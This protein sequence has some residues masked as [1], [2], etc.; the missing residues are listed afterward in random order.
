[1][2]LVLGLGIKGA[3]QQRVNELDVSYFIERRN[4]DALPQYFD[5]IIA[6]RRQDDAEFPEQ[7]LLQLS[8]AMPLACEPVVEQGRPVKGE[9][10]EKVATK[11][12]S[13][14]LKVLGRPA[15]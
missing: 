3:A 4:F 14:R 2:D 11:Q 15:S 6:L 7:L 9:A 1:M 12:C 13:Q 8:K 10:F 5:T